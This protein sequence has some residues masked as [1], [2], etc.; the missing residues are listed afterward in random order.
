MTSFW[1]LSNGSKATGSEAD[2]F[3]SPMGTIPDGTTATAVIQKFTVDKSRERPYINIHWKLTEGEFKGRVVFQKLECW[4]DKATKADRAKNMLLLIYTLLNH[5]PSH[6]N[7]PNDKDFAPM[8][9]RVLGIKI[10]EWHMISEKTGEPMSGNF[11]SEI[12]S[13]KE[14]ECVT[15]KYASVTSV[16][17]SVVDSA[18]SRNPR[19][20]KVD[21][22]LGDDVPF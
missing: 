16:S 18:L 2:S 21:N 5:V 1:E 7:E 20:A 10:N 12:H 11:I 22:E 3:I 17:S 15:G 4:H 19:Q 9:N 14:F 8:V 13:A 6:G